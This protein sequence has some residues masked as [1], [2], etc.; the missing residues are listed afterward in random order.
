MLTG[1]VNL[2]MKTMYVSDARALAVLSVYS[3][4]VCGVPWALEA[5]RKTKA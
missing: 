2:T 3:L 4:V 1:A 5:R